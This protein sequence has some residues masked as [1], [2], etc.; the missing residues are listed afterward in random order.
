MHHFFVRIALL[1]SGL[2]VATFAAEPA[3]APPWESDALNLEAGVLWQMG[4]STPIA[5]RVLATEF[6]WRSGAFMSHVYANGS[7]IVVRHRLTLIAD[8][9]E[10]GP[11]SHYLA[12]AGS[13]SIEWWDQAGTRSW[14]AGIGGGFGWIDSSGVPGGQPQ[15]LT[16]NWFIRTGIER[17]TTRKNSWSAG[18]L[19]QHISN[20]GMTQPHP[21]MN[22]VG[23]TLG[24][25]W[26]R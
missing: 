10:N 26:A 4:S 11:E 19:Y 5:Y 18:I 7:R 25:S 2:C 16:L 20:G 14:F 21:G 23:F 22:T 6:S 13:P 3:P 9:I 8:V 12:I 1:G 17:I 15:D 24:Y